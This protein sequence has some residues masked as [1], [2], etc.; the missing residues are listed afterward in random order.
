MRLNGEFPYLCHQAPPRGIVILATVI[1]NNICRNVNCNASPLWLDMA[2][3]I[4]GLR[5]GRA[6]RGLGSGKRGK[7]RGL[8]PLTFQSTI[9]IV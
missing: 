1:S 6:L 9:F 4:R 2:A 5:A 3:L 7:V 8:W